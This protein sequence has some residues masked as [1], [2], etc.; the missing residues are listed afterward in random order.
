MKKTKK[1]LATPAARRIAKERS[2]DL[3]LIKG[4]GKFGSIKMSDVELNRSTQKITPVAKKM[5]QYYNIDIN[6]V[7]L[8]NRKIHKSDIMNLIPN[9]QINQEKLDENTTVSENNSK[10]IKMQGMRKVI[11]ERMLESVQTAPQYTLTTEFDTTNLVAL[12]DEAKS[13]FNK[14]TGNKLTFTDLIVKITALTIAKHPIINSSI[15]DGNIIYND[16][17]NIGIA[18]ALDDGLIVP[19]I[20]NVNKHSLFDINKIGKDIIKR[21]RLGK[22]VPTEYIG[23]TFTISNM[24]MYPVDYSTPIINQP[25]SAILG[26][27]RTQKKPVIIDD[28]IV[29]RSMTGFS[30]TLDHRNIDG[31][32]GCQFLKTFKELVENPLC[33]LAK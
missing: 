8:E 12:L 4:T 27:G 15:K 19:V 13:I 14:V 7:S 30:L 21:A 28:E 11:A 9:N 26:I 33:I 20:K 2:I 1:V 3:S 16:E 18:V 22:L 24:G 25:E 17:I 23:G 10:G 29:V 6:Q 32:V 5:A 31:V